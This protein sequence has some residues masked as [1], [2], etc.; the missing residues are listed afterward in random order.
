VPTNLSWLALLFVIVLVWLVGMR[1]QRHHTKEHNATLTS[2]VQ[3]LLKPHTPDDC[4]RCRKQHPTDL[5]P[6]PMHPPIRPWRELKSRRG[7]P[8]R[9]DTQGFACPNRMCIYHQITDAQI[10]AL[11]GD[12]AEGK[13]E[14]IQTLR[15]QA[16]G[17]TFSVRHATPLYRLK[18]ASHRVAEV[19]TALAE[20]LDVAAAVRVFGHRH[21]TITTWL[22]RAGEH[23]ATL[24]DHFFRDLQL[25]HIQLDEIR[26]RLRSRAQSLWLWLAIDPITKL[27][28]V[29]HLGSRTQD[30]AHALVHDLRQRLAPGCL[31]LF[32]SD[33]LNQY[34]YALT[35]HFGQWVDGVGRRVRAWQVA[36]GLIYGQVKKTYRRRRL[37][38]VRTVMQCGTRTALQVALIGLG[39]SGRV[40]TAFIERL[41]LTVRQSVA[42][43]VRRTWSTAQD[44]A[45]LLLHLEWWRAYYHFVRPHVALREALAQPIARGGRRHPHRYRQRTPAMAA[46]LTSRRWRVRE[47]LAMPLPAKPQGVG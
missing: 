34:F 46:G 44:G 47:V 36:A 41:N 32:T 14:R 3:R 35:A 17:S 8:K 1:H 21:A 23:S 31:P 33:G 45:Q 42:A 24:H 2:A 28:P 38:R 27:V 13:A 15:C 30:A 7:A 6:A 19:L 5:A 4:P 16:C 43:L 22:T 39:L 37:V 25:P 18:T 20:G 11:V 9:I 10:H 26:T 12:G 40:T 29:L